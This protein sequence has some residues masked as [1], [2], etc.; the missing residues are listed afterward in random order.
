MGRWYSGLRKCGGGDQG[1]LAAL[2]C[3]RV[4][5]VIVLMGNVTL[6]GVFNAAGGV[7]WESVG[8]GSVV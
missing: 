2:L 8:W 7:G 6:M 5:A 1:I 4:G 3:R